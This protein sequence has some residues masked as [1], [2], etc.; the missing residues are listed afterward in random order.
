MWNKSLC[1]YWLFDRKNSNKLIIIT[2]VIIIIIMIIIDSFSKAPFPKTK[3]K[4]DAL[5]EMTDIN[6]V[7]THT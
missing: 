2:I 6:Y 1:Q 4:L 7:N 5:Y 3:F